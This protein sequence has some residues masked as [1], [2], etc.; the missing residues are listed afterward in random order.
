MSSLYKSWYISRYICDLLLVKCIKEKKNK[1]NEKKIVVRIILPSV[2]IRRD[3]AAMPAILS[4]SPVLIMSLISI[5]PVVNP[6]I[7]EGVPVGSKKA[8]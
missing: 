3:R 2:G 5:C 6:T 7:L 8:N 4:G 1:N